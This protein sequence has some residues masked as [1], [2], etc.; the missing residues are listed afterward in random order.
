MRA[1][2]PRAA[3]LEEG[4]RCGASNKTDGTYCNKASIFLFLLV[5]LVFVCQFLDLLPSL[6]LVT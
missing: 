1:F 4:N 5:S 3:L 2:R 6:I